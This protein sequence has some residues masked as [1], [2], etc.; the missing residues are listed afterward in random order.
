[1]SNNMLN[2]K[3]INSM[4][5]FLKYLSYLMVIVYI[6]FSSILLFTKIFATLLQPSQ[7]YALGG[8]FL[9]YGLYRCYRVYKQQKTDSN[10]NEE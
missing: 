5:L 9:I 2:E 7:R 8:L 10:E 4:K 1:M 3:M 6:V